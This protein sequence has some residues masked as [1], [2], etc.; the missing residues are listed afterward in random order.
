MSSRK[1]IGRELFSAIKANC[2]SNDRGCWEYQGRPNGLGYRQITISGKRWMVHRVMFW[3]ENGPFPIEL[4]ICHTCDNPPCCNPAHLFKGNASQNI[5]DS[6]IKN[7]HYSASKD[8]CERGHPYIEH[9]RVDSKSGNRH[10]KFCDR[11]RQRIYAGWP[12]EL[13]Y[14]LPAQKLGFRP[15]IVIPGPQVKRGPK[16]TCKHGHEL[17]GGNLYITTDG[18]RQCKRCRYDA[19]IRASLKRNQSDALPEQEK[20]P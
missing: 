1:I 12:E 3:M 19:V 2:I 14:S 11:A 8:K 13:A 17:A 15:S 10:C 18:R 4:D 16:T 9:G 6:V 7:R 20:K 5:L